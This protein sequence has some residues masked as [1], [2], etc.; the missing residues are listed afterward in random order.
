MQ[1]PYTFRWFCILA[2]LAQAAGANA[3][4]N[5]PAVQVSA[6]IQLSMVGE[7][8]K[9]DFP[10]VQVSELPH[11]IVLQWND[12]KADLGKLGRCAT[13]FDRGGGSDKEAFTCSIYVKISAVAARK[14][15]TRCE[16]MRASKKIAAPCKIIR[17]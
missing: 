7:T 17:D 10:T 9:E 6:P 11:T 13:A 2:L 12:Y 5:A 3:S 14:A 15:M 1:F 4:E 8:A 16:E